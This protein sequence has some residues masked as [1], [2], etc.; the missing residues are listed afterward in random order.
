MNGNNSRIDQFM[1]LKINRKLKRIIRSREESEVA[2]D[3]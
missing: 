1:D 3:G 2:E